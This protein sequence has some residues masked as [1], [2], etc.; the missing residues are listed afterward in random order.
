MSHL[1]KLRDILEDSALEDEINETL[2]NNLRIP[3]PSTQ[4]IATRKEIF[5]PAHLIGNVMLQM[6]SNN[7][8]TR[9]HSLVVNIMKS[10]KTIAM[11]THLLYIV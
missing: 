5:F 3:L 2:I 8:T 11:V 4:A 9:L 6:I 10:I 1:K 7:F